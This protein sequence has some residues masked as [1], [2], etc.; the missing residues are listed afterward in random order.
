[1]NNNNN[2]N[3]DGSQSAISDPNEILSKSKSVPKDF[4][5]NPDTISSS[6]VL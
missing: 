3:N 5:S 1:M 2:N 6:T 4:L